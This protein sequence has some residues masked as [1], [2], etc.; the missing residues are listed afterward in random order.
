MNHVSLLLVAFCI[1]LSANAAMQN[2]TVAIRE[3]IQSIGQRTISGTVTDRK[4][5]PVIGATVKVR[6]KVKKNTVTDI[7]G[8]FS[9]AEVPDSCILD[10][11]YVGYTPQE[12]QVVPDKNVY[13]IVMRV[14]YAVLDEVVVVGYATQKKVDLTGQCR[15]SI[16]MRLKTAL[17]QTP[18]THLPVLRQVL[19]S[20]IRVGILRDM[21]RRAYWFAVKAHLT[22]RLR[23]LWWTA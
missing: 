15:Q 13:S 20:R 7:D 10:V 18:P 1:G 4:G 11:S 12:V 3:Q 21:N 8:N 5:Q 2:D 16:S 22:I 23:L 14:N 9:I 6:E 19:P 17:S